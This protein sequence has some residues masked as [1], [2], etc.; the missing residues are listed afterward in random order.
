M[1]DLNFRPAINVIECKLYYLLIG[2][3]MNACL[4]CEK[5]TKNPKYCSRSCAVTV[6]NKIA[7]K[8]KL[9]GFCRDC[10]G[11]IPGGRNAFCKQCWKNRQK[12]WS[13]VTLMDLKKGNANNYGYPQIRQMSRNLYKKSGRP[14][15]C[16]VCQY[17]LHVDIC[18][19]KDVNSYSLDTPITEINSLNN[20]TALC[21]NHHWEFDN[22]YL[23]PF[24]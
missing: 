3:Q 21:K 9:T 20:L 8:R 19:I 5:E 2:Y 11:K 18:H 10:Q 17:E 13:K 23:D 22:G 16:L 15:Q 14:M 1:K 7:P 24:I 6:H 4:Y 12:D